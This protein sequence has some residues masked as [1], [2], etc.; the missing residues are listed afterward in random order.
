MFSLD[1]DYLK[2]IKWQSSG[3]IIAQAVNIMS[4]P[5]VTRL[6]TPSEVGVLNI[7][8]QAL[9]F[10]T[11]IISF[12]VEHVVML[13]KRDRHARELA[14]FIFGFGVISCLTLLIMVYA[15]LQFDLIPD[16]YRMWAPL[17]PIV[18]FLTVLSQ[19][20]Q[21][22]SQRSANFKLSGLSEVV[23]RVTNSLFAIVGGFLSGPGVVLGIAVGVGFF[24]KTLTFWSSI[25]SI[26]KTIWSGAI[27]GV[28]RIKRLSL[29]RLLGSLIV[30]HGLL[31]IT[32][33]APLWYMANEW[34][35]D[36]VGY[37][38]LVLATLAL[39]T[40]LLGNAVGQ[41]FYQRAAS[42]F[43]QNNSFNQL[44]IK[45]FKLLFLIALP[46][47]SVVFFF[48]GYL[49]PL[50]F[51]E[52]WSAAGIV[53]QYY[54]F[55]A[56]L[57]F[58]SVPFDRSGLIVNAWWYG[59]SWHVLRV[60]TTLLV[61]YISDLF[62]LSFYDFLL[63]LTIQA[64]VMYVIDLAASFIFSRRSNPFSSKMFAC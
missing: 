9:A 15:L 39:P 10:A 50:I 18:A 48:G 24:F 47:F 14:S 31:A 21:Q 25:Q 20:V 26:N 33:M 53:A 36:Y 57:S 37:F 51:G 7:F 59:P 29:Q 12:R 45:N 62:A 19:G 63:L 30:S 41:V 52:S 32:S 5:I 13:P 22:L 3:N 4:L 1:K 44:M 40:R 2:N 55:A 64:A 23:N 11:I 60:I 16:E 54:V 17:L 49:Y 28:R 56:A 61:I 38:S 43:A 46:G 42:S 58:L 8:V 35:N 6:F 34:G 27:L